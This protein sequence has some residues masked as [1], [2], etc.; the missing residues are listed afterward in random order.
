MP[1]SAICTHSMRCTRDDSAD[2]IAELAGRSDLGNK[3]ETNG[4][5]STP[6]NLK[7]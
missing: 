4:K 5:Q 7:K 6:Q 3:R 2:K 1:T